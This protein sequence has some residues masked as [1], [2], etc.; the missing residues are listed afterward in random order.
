MCAGTTVA[1]NVVDK[2]HNAL[3]SNL[4][5]PTDLIDI[6]YHSSYP[7]VVVSMHDQPRCLPLTPFD[8][9]SRKLLE[10]RAT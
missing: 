8:G 10:A 6:K 4:V 2:K 7:H 1:L 3:L 5:T 9:A